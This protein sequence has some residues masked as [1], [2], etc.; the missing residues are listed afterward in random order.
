MSDPSA[1]LSSGLGLQAYT[2][3]SGVHHPVGVMWCWGWNQGFVYATQ[4]LHQ[5]TSLRFTFAKA[6][7]KVYALRYQL[8]F[9]SAEGGRP[10]GLPF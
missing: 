1:S 9:L 5:V 7:G 3:I 8:L 6:F 4:A 10:Q 2:G